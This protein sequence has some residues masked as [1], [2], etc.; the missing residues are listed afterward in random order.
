MD[1]T[2]L[3]ILSM[4]GAAAVGGVVGFIVARFSRFEIG[5]AV[6]LIICGGVTLFFAAK[7]FLDYRA[8]TTAGADA[9]WGEV[10]QIVDK[11]G[12]ESG[13]ITSPAPIVRFTA[14]DGAVHTIEGPTASGAVVGQSVWVLVDRTHP[15]RSRMGQVDQ[16]RGAAIAFMLFGTFPMSFAVMLLAWVVDARRAELQ[17]KAATPRARGGAAA[18]RAGIPPK[19][20]AGKAS[21]SWVLGAKIVYAALFASIVWIAVPGEDLLIRFGQGFAGLAIS[22]LALALLGWRVG[23]GG[24][25]WVVAVSM[26]ALNFGMWSFALYLLS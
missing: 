15:E 13:S 25:S 2:S 8:F 5:L 14:P 20:G 17:P 1:I 10:I 6:A 18:V 21:R 19:H 22:L 7:C 9:V 16:L 23:P 11:P 26:L 4:F 24:L 3:G 12:N